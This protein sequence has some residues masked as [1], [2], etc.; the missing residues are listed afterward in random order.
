MPGH[1]GDHGV[2]GPRQFLKK[3]IH[4]TVIVF[5]FASRLTCRRIPVVPVGVRVESQGDLEKRE[6]G[7]SAI[8]CIQ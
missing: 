6:V 1:Q 4:A 5:G 2:A 3:S 7:W 8:A